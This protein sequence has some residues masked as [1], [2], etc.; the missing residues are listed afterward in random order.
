MRPEISGG[1]KYFAR[2]DGDVLYFSIPRGQ[3]FKPESGYGVL[4]IYV[5]KSGAGAGEYEEQSL[6][7]P[8]DVKLIEF[9]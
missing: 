5:E 2:M 7:I 9:D 8:P 3:M 4:K 6:E 1:G